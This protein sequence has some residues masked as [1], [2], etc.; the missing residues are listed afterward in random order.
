MVCFGELYTDDIQKTL[1]THPSSLTQT[2]THTIGDNSSD[3]GQIP[4]IN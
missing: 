3:N 1:K 4:Y 2:E